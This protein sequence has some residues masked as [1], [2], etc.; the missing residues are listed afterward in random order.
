MVPATGGVSIVTPSG[1]STT[2]SGQGSVSI[3]HGLTTT[4]RAYHH[5]QRQSQAINA[6][7]DAVTYTNSS[8]SQSS[9]DT[10]S[11]DLTHDVA[12]G[13]TYQVDPRND[14]TTA[15]AAAGRIAYIYQ[16]YGED[17]ST[18]PDQAAAVQLAIYQLLADP[19]AG[20]LT[21]S[22]MCGCC[23][24]TSNFS[25]DFGS[26]PDAAAITALAN[27]YLG[28]SFGHRDGRLGGRL[29]P[30]HYL[31]PRARSAL[32]PAK[33]NFGDYQQGSAYGTVFNDANGNG[34]EQDGKPGLS[35][36]T[37]QLLNGSGQVVATMPSDANGNYAFPNLAP[38]TYGVRE[39]PQSGWSPTTPTSG[40][41]T[42]QGGAGSRRD[43]GNASTSS[44]QLQA[45]P[46]SFDPSQGYLVPIG[47]AQVDPNS[48]ALILSQPLD[49]SRSD[50]GRAFDSPSLVYNSSTVNNR[51]IID[52]TLASSPSDPVPTSIVATLTIDGT[53]QAPVTF[54]TTGHQ[55]GD[56]YLVAVQ[57]ATSLSTGIHTWQLE[58]DSYLP[59]GSVVVRTQTGQLGAVDRSQSS[60]GGWSLSD[61]NQLF[62]DPATG[63]VLWVSGQGESQIFTSNGNGTFTSPSGDFG[64]LVQDPTTQDFTYTTPQQ[65]VSNFNA[66]GL[67][68]S[69]VDPHGLTD[70]F[71]YNG[72]NQLTQVTNVDGG[73][74]TLQYGSGNK[75]T[76]IAEPGSRT[77]TLNQNAVTGNLDSLA[78]EDGN[79]RLFAYAS[80]LPNLLTN[81]TWGPWNSSFSYDDQSG[82]TGRLNGA[83][84]APGSTYQIV[85]A[86]VQGLGPV[87][88]SANQAAATVTDGLGRTTNYQ[89]DQLG[90]RTGLTRPD[91]TSESW[92]RDM[93]GQV[94]QATDFLGL[95][96]TDAY[97]EGPTGQGDL[98]AIGYPDGTLEAMAY[99]LT[100]HEVTQDVDRMGR[101][102]NAVVDPT[103]GDVTETIDPMGRVTQLGWSDGLLTSMTDPLGRVT[104]DLCDAYGS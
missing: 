20:S 3:G 45:G 42:V 47:E 19:S 14:L 69:Q 94:T 104:E 17:L 91:G 70:S 82:G 98:T 85:P 12:S 81:D 56:T 26:N 1:S 96:T 53:A 92:D 10:F 54:S 95:T 31:G 37:V 68:T 60:F 46:R 32:A 75:L 101:V 80:N 27:Q 7:Q 28:S 41:V 36:W 40:N 97:D 23:P 57:A 72:L 65:L 78:D 58:V 48:G 77:V 79:T 11:I 44:W 30:G 16:T 5:L 103:N 83:Q 99:D 33:L 61:L 18:N 38:G 24:S 89:L 88:G 102:T 76:G 21:L 90:R 87:A 50:S 100:F 4:P 29:C 66:D 35:G 93:Q 51:P 34:I 49:F 55:P 43:F 52:A 13:Q 63:N 22:M 2:L 64:T 86:A 25:V 8:G 6:A 73:V 74:T 9:F 84:L 15:T 59:G 39:V 71:A 62:Q 67:L